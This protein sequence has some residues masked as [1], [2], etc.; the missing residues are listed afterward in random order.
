MITRY[1]RIQYWCITAVRGDGTVRKGGRNYAPK[2]FNKIK[3]WCIAAIGGDS[4]FWKDRRN[5]IKQNDLK[6]SKEFMWCIACSATIRGDSRFRKI[7]LNNKNN[8]FFFGKKKPWCSA[9][10]GGDGRFGKGSAQWIVGDCAAGYCAA[11]CQLDVRS[12]GECLYVCITYHMYI[13]LY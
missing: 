4:R 8:F 1:N 10:I 3:P 7:V 5:R 6:Q 9:A 12:G 13:I 2:Q 11:F